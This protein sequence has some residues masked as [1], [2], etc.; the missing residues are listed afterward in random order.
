LEAIE[1][2]VIDV[3]E[4]TAQLK[5]RKITITTVHKDVYSSSGSGDIK[6]YAAGGDIPEPTLLYGLNSQR[7][8][9]IAGEK[10]PERV[11]PGS[12]GNSNVNPGTA[13]ITI[14]LDGRVIARA[15]RQ[16]LYEDIIISTGL[17]A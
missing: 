4:A 8:Y 11:T 6:E 10:R 1:Q 15:L 3:N 5:N 9:A 16:P 13:N 2:H 17:R 7:V 14:M 12:G